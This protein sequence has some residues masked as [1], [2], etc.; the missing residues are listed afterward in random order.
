MP[1]PEI[2]SRD[3]YVGE[4]DAEARAVVGS[5][6]AEGYRATGRDVMLRIRDF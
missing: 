2:G 6:L 5:I 3:I 1:P 4:S